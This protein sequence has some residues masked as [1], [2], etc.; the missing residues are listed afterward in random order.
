MEENQSVALGGILETDLHK[1]APIVWQGVNGE[2]LGVHPQKGLFPVSSSKTVIFAVDDLCVVS[3]RPTKI[4]V[5]D[6]HQL[7]VH[8]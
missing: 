1:A 6:D 3:E 7:H 4:L 5:H 2:L 8:G